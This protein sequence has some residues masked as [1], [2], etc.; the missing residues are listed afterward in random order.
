MYLLQF[1]TLPALKRLKDSLLIS[2][3]NKN[4]LA[5]SNRQLSNFTACCEE[6]WWGLWADYQ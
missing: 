6:K 1:L 5:L 2:F 3:V 4:F